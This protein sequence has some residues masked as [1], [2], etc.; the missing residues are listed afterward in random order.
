MKSDAKWIWKN[1]CVDETRLVLFRKEFTLEE[2]PGNYIINISADSRYKL[3]VN[4]NF[5]CGGPCRSSFNYKYYE[6]VDLAPFLN[7]GQNTIAVEVAHYSNDIHSSVCFN[8]GPISVIS[9]MRGGLIVI[10]KTENGVLNSN[11]TWKCYDCK[12]HQLVK[13]LLTSFAD[14]NDEIDGTKYP[15]GW[16]TNNFDDNNFEFSAAILPNETCF[17]GGILL[18]WILKKREIPLPYLKKVYFKKIM[19]HSGNILNIENILENKTIKVDKNSHAWLELDIGEYINAEICYKVFGGFGGKIDIVYSESYGEYKACG[20]FIK[21]IRDDC[22]H[23]KVLN[24]DTQTIYCGKSL[25]EYNPFAYKTFRFLRIDIYTKEQE[26]ELESIDVFETGYPFDIKGSFESNS[27]EYDA[28]WDI[29]VRTIMRCTYETFMD[30]PYY[31][32]MQYIMDTMLQAAFIY[33]VTDDHRLIRKA[34]EDFAGAQLHDGIIPCNAPSKFIQIIPGFMFYFVYMLNDYYVYTGDIEFVKKYIPTVEKIF[35]YFKEFITEKKLI[36]NSGYWQFVD[37][38]H[39]WSSGCPTDNDD[40]INFIYSMMMVKA[41]NETQMMLEKMGRHDVAKEYRELGF[42]ISTAINAYGWD[43]ETELYDTTSNRQKQ[44]SQHAQV[45]AVLSGVAS[46]ERAE[47]IM[48]KAVIDNSLS[49]CS[50][51]MS[52]FLFRALEK[53]GLYNHTEKLLY[54]WTDL[55]RLNVTTW[56]EDQ[57]TQRSD[58][59]AWSSAPLYELMSCYI[60]IKPL[61]PGFEK[62]LIKPIGTWL[63]QCSAE[64][65]TPKGIIKARYTIAENE[66]KLYVTLPE[67]IETVVEM[68]NGEIYIFN[69]DSKKTSL[70]FAISSKIEYNFADMLSLQLK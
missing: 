7:A 48:K 30:C 42:E 54:E 15:F 53:T 60:G 18:P 67:I 49:K 24:G 58:C 46:D 19:R 63:T 4:N 29:S 70:T 27:E 22:S 40:E 35:N 56:P 59:H 69:A 11:E 28:L 62:V 32:R 55:L 45:W 8:N 61:E 50:Y 23:N 65:T 14:F 12:E 47:S 31:E 16:K 38:V 51:A 66:I 6:E 34:I 33:R 41:L 17:G 21:D 64:V 68:P 13:S 5:I 43:D 10:D 36:E 44:K 20:T 57:V 25:Q 37:W 52:Y 9:T 39:G 2:M 26:L 3:Y 1:Y